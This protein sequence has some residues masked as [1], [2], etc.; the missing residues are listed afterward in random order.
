VTWCGCL[1]GVVVQFHWFGHLSARTRVD[2]G[3]AFAKVRPRYVILVLPSWSSFAHCGFL[4]VFSANGRK[5]IFGGS[6]CVC[7]RVDGSAVI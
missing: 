1:R 3:G 6:V 2:Q 7:E 5:M 4:S